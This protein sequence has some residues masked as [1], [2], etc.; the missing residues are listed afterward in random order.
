MDCSPRGYRLPPVSLQE[1]GTGTQERLS[2][3]ASATLPV[4]CIQLSS[5]LLYAVQ[6]PS[7][8]TGTD[9]G[10]AVSV[11]VI[12]TAALFMIIGF[13]T[14]L[15]VMYLRYHKKAAHFPAAEGQ[16]NARSTAPVGPVYEEVSP[17]EEIELNTNQAY[18]PL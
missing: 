4:Y 15:L 10:I 5:H 17:K 9:L 16:G 18:G 2:V 12:I 7:I 13:L 8:F 3:E 6:S 14:G 1:I 11:S